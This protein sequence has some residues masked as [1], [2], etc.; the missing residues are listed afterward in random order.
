MTKLN[1]DM[2]DKILWCV[3]DDE[4]V[5]AMCFFKPERKVDWSSGKTLVDGID[6]GGGGKFYFFGH[7]NFCVHNDCADE[8][9]PKLMHRIEVRDPFLRLAKS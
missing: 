1:R 7:V 6:L 2:P 9:Q 4:N 8:C 3:D 5:I